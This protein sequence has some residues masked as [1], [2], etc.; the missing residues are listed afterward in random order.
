MKGHVEA[1]LGLGGQLPLARAHF[2]MQWPSG[3]PIHLRQAG[4]LS[5]LKPIRADGITSIELSRENLLPALPPKGAPARYRLGRVVEATDFADWTD[6][7]ALM[8][9]LYDKA[10]I[11]PAQGRFV[12]NSPV[13]R[14]C[15]PIPRFGPK[16]HSLSSRSVCVTSHW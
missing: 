13:S 8:A 15:P 1:T 10:A 9:P 12:R 14:P 11:V 6:L 5:L 3:L 16:R 4:D 2:R 7:A